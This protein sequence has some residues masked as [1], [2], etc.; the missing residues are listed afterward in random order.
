LFVVHRFLPKHQ[1]GTEI[2]THTLAREMAKKHDVAILTSEDADLP[3]GQYHLEKDDYEGL[4]VYRILRGEPGDFRASYQD[5]ELDGIFDGLVERLKPDFVHFQHLYRLSVGFISVLAKREIPRVL[6]LADYWFICPSVI[7]LKPGFVRCEGPEKGYACANC[8]NAVGQ[9]FAGAAAAKLFGNSP[10][11]QRAVQAMHKLKHNMPE[12]VVQLAKGIKDQAVSH[13]AAGPKRQD[14]LRQ[15]FDTIL[16]ALK[17]TN[18]I[19]A[20]SRF[21]RERYIEAGVP[22]FNISYSDY[23]FD[24]DLFPRKARKKFEPPLKIGYIGT[25]VAHKG[26]HVLVEA[27]KYV[28]NAELHI[29]GDTTHFPNYVKS[30][31]KAARGLPVRFEGRFDHDRAA[32]ILS[33]MDVLVVPSLWWENSPL[34]IHE[35]FLMGIPVLASRCGGMGE[36]VADDMFVFEPGDSVELGRMLQRLAQKPE[37]ANAFG[38]RRGQV[39]TIQENVLEMEEVYD[40]VMKKMAEEKAR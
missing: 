36:L 37:L 22:P 34:T 35:A 19:L 3:P 7:M 26:V 31:E 9:E 13:S 10:A 2:Y 18:L 5:D 28:S 27:M 29:H 1:A 23:G 24:I 25:L 16:D 39:K 12:S 33:G 17:K 20:P 32:E 15:R 14:L 30:L 8:G 38:N 4:D 40:I 11:R 6:T 21:L